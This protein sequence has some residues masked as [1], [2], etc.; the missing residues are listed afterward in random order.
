M[1][2]NERDS[3]N[4]GDTAGLDR[5]EP[6][7]SVVIP[8][9]DEEQFMEQCIASLKELDYPRDKIEVIFA[10]GRSTD[11]TRDIASAHGYRVIDNPGL[12][13]SAGRNAGFA[14][15]RG[16]IV[17]FTDADCVFP[18]MWIRNAVKYFRST[19]AGGVSGP[20]PLPAG[21]DAFGKAVGI[22][23]DL[24]GM[25]GGTVH[26]RE[27]AAPRAVD[28]LPGCNCFY[29]R[30]ALQKIMPTTTD[31]YSNEDVE[32][33]AQLRR[34][35]VKLLMTPDVLVYHHKRSSPG[36]FWKQ[37]FTFAI[38]RLQLGKRDLAFLKPGHWLIGAGVP[39]ALT[40]FIAAGLLAP[41]F[42]LAGLIAVA[43][44]VLGTL[45]YYGFKIS[46]GVALNVIFAL[47]L[48][49]TAWPLGFLRELLLPVGS[50]T[51]AKKHV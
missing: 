37:M 31:L 6:V 4:T 25:A 9:R 18:P 3:N 51:P 12:K 2:R 32:M 44:A 47:A 50:Y 5:S 29:R 43:A 23:F 34:N 46:L 40:L 17:A 36:R 35:G 30:E 22:V 7:V 1:N 14:A 24:A 27:V 38:G 39:I 19:D 15:S 20:T 28:D 48:F 10:D 33:N 21:Q 8:V 16:K 26:L 11:R 41:G 42:C 13:I 45:L 49:A